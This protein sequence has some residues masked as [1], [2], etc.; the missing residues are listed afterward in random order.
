MEM[1]EP[2]C[3]DCSQTIKRLSRFPLKPIAYEKWR[4]K[5]TD[6]IIDEFLPENEKKKSA[7]EKAIE[8]NDMMGDFEIL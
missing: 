8:D 2:I 1:D 7:A 3:P 5:E 4:E 6:P